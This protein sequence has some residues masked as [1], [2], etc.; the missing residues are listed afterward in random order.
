VWTGTFV[1]SEGMA[2]ECVVHGVV[3]KSWQ[4]SKSGEDKRVSTRVLT[5]MSFSCTDDPQADS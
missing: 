4:C 3:A 1:S 5:H 2:R